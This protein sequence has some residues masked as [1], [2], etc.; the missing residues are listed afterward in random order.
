MAHTW[1]SIASNEVITHQELQ[2]QVT[3]GAIVLKSGQ[4]IALGSDAD[5]ALTKTRLNQYVYVSQGNSLLTSKP[6]NEV[7]VKQDITPIYPALT[8]E[9]GTKEYN[10]WLGLATADRANMNYYDT[11]TTYTVG[12]KLVYSVLI[13]NTGTLA[14]QGNMVVT[15]TLPTGTTVDS[16]VPTH[17]VPAEVSYSVVGSTL[18]VTITKLIGIYNS[19]TYPL[20]WTVSVIL[21]HPTPTSAT[22]PYS[23]S[24]LTSI[25]T[26]YGS[27]VPLVTTK[28][29]SMGH[30]NLTVSKTSSYAA[31][32]TIPYIT[33]FDYTIT[34]GISNSHVAIGAQITDTLNTGLTFVSIVSTPSGWTS[35]VSGQVVTFSKATDEGVSEAPA[36]VIR[37]KSNTENV[38]ITNRAIHSAT[39]AYASVFS[40]RTNYFDYNRVAIITSQGYTTCY[41]GS[42]LPVY[43]DTN[44]YSAT[45]NNYYVLSGS[46]ISLN[47]TT[48]PSSAACYW[49]SV[50][51][52]ST[53]ASSTTRTRNNCGA[54]ST[55]STVT[56]NQG[57]VFGI[58]P[59]GQFRSYTSQADA[60]SQ[61][62]T[63]ADALLQTNLQNYANT[64][65]TCTWSS[66]R[67]ATCGG[68]YTKNNCASNC[69]GNGTVYYTSPTYTRSAN[70]TVSQADADTQA[71]NSANAAACADR[72]ANG[73][74][75]ANN[76]GS[77]CC[78]NLEYYCSGCSQRSRERNSCDNSLRND[79]LVSSS[80]CS[81]GNTCGGTY[82]SYYCSGT[83]RMRELRYSCDGS[84]AGTTETY[85]TCDQAN[86]GASTSPTYTDQGYTTCVSCYQAQVYKD[87][88]A[89]SGTYNG[90]YYQN[91]SGNK[92][93]VGGQPSGTPCNTNSS[94]VDSGSG[95]CSGA[96]YVIN[97]TQSNPC[98][99]A[100]CS[101]RVIET[102]SVTYGCYT[103]PPSCYNYSII[104]YNGFVTVSG[105]YTTCGGSASTFSG[106]RNASFGGPTGTTIC[107]RQ[108]TV[109][110]TSGNGTAQ[111]GS[112]CAAT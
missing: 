42:N 104:A 71:Q 9:Y 67:S 5:K 105:N 26:P 41:N 32:A 110:V 78:W 10:S 94:C 72:D 61:A 20:A 63:Y 58:S 62:Q 107:A 80:T 112:S 108:G 99:G 60:N 92:V 85:A 57:D 2:N 7:V 3:A 22:N 77:C 17:L 43:R 49:D 82:W 35:S 56:I 74:T 12:K 1:S 13:K 51:T 81:C 33:N 100:S 8:V 6:N 18:T 28:T 111:Q 98:S 16:V 54:G 21:N 24:F 96:N 39:N 30:P 19:S 83:T 23:I 36:F 79:T 37:V 91:Q 14:T 45:A 68:G 25:T 53:L 66:S 64:Y 40:D 47:T 97:Q 90:Y 29:V 102:N 87:T 55:A 52:V 38:N 59:T 69:Y 65:G 48:A 11:G 27:N 88:N 86:C 31:G 101:V 15:I 73:Q 70:S 95:Y 109:S 46:Y 84:Y 76:N 93:Y 106:Y 103:P 44:A 50:Y 34:A 75:Y 89:C 4:T